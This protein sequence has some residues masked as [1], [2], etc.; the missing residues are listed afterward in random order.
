MSL[1]LLKLPQFSL[2]LLLLSQDL[3]TLLA[4]VVLQT[5]SVLQQLVLQ[6]VLLLLDPLKLLRPLYSHH[7]LLPGS[8]LVLRQLF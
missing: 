8:L 7:D 6:I 2:L 4:Q 5:L 1:A 3:A